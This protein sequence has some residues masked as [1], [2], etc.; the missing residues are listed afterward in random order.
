MQQFHSIHRLAGYVTYVQPSATRYMNNID[1]RDQA[2]D[3]L[4]F[5]IGRNMK[6]RC[7]TVNAMSQGNHRPIQPYRILLKVPRI[8]ATKDLTLFLAASILLTKGYKE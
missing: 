3:F 2:L 5:R 8:L 1:I 4:P 6:P 7:A